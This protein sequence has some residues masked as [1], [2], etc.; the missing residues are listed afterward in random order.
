MPPPTTQPPIT[1]LPAQFTLDGAP[2]DCYAADITGQYIVG[3]TLTSSNTI[4]LNVTVAVAGTY[5]ITTDTV[6]G[7]YF[8]ASGAFDHTGGQVVT[9]VANGRIDTPHNFHF[10]VLNGVSP[11]KFNIYSVDFGQQA[12]YVLESGGGNSNPCIFTVE[13]DYIH[14]TPVTSSNTVTI[15]AYFTVGGK[16]TIETN[17]VNGMHFYLSDV[18]NGTGYQY[19]ALPAIGTPLAAGTYSFT[20][21]I[22]G[23]HP[24]GGEFCGFMVTVQ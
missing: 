21:E 17:T 3:N 8:A 1:P 13:G 9:L 24:I 12:T 14:Q 7:V 5:S 10:T 18:I 4:R 20:P 23:P 22:V 6:N 15:R 11:C 2:N 19:I 16:F